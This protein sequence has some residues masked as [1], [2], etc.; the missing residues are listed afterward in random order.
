MFVCVCFAFTG[1]AYMTK[2]K[3]RD[4]KHMCLLA[5]STNALQ[6]V[7]RRRARCERDCSGDLYRGW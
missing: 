4:F 1:F 3:K 2:D 5:I 6:H 7:G